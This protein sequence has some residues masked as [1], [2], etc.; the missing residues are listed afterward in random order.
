MDATTIIIYHITM[1]DV[2]LLWRL[3]MFEQ[4]NTLKQHNKLESAH[5]LEPCH[6]ESWEPLDVFAWFRALA[7]GSA[8]LF[9]D[10]ALRTIVWCAAIRS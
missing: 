10:S 6:N 3:I 4:R 1:F 8:R 7:A 2:T 5:K 9:A